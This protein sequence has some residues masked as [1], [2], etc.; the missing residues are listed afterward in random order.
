LRGGVLNAATN[1]TVADL[2]EDPRAKTSALNLLGVFY[3]FGALFLP[4][5]ISA[6]VAKL[7]IDRLVLAAAVLC[8]LAGL[9]PIAL[10]F[11]LA[12]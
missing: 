12:K 2:H 5:M 9:F 10:T 1:T 8:T 4:F 6:L 3:G 11:P 7:G